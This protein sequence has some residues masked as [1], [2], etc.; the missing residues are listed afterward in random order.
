[1]ARTV[2]ESCLLSFGF[3]SSSY[4]PICTVWHNVPD[5]KSLLRDIDVDL[6]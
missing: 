5:E 1:M 6:S 3:Q 2:A 4:H